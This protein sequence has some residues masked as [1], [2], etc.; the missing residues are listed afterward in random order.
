MLQI[1]MEMLEMK[2]LARFAHEYEFF[3]AY[4]VD[5]LK[6]KIM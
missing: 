1:S 5:M 6:Q 2:I 3:F 4:L